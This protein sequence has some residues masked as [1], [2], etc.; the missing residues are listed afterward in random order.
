MS[1][2]RR[3]GILQLQSKAY[4]WL[5]QPLQLCITAMMQVFYGDDQPSPRKLLIGVHVSPMS[6]PSSS[7]GWGS[8]EAM[9][10]GSP[11]AA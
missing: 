10:V 5:V 2:Y 1:T 6:R 9:I 4:L 8:T 11:R 7:G 3:G